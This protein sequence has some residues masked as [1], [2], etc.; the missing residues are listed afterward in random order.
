MQNGNI[1]L[2]CK[3]NDMKDRWKTTKVANDVSKTA[4]FS[5]MRVQICLTSD[6][7]WKMDNSNDKI[8][9]GKAYKKNID[10]ILSNFLVSFVDLYRKNV[11]YH[12]ED[13][14]RY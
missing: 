10:A 7:K 3:R 12:N 9:N 11:H 8:S 14:Q 1:F 13:S 2:N 6:H 4:S 5:W